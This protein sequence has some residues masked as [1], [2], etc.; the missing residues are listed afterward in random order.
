VAP[1]RAYNRRVAKGLDAGR[2]AALIDALARSLGV[3]LPA[4]SR[5]ALVGYV[6]RVA[7]WNQKLDLTAARTAVA[8][9]EVLLADALILSDPALVP[10]GCR[11]VD[12]GSGV[13]APALPLLALRTDLSATLVEPK[14]KRVAF[15]RGVIG[16]LG[17][18]A[19][20]QVLEGRIEP[21]ADGSALTQAH[22]LALSRA[23]LAPPAWLALGTRLAPAVLVLVASEPLPDAPEGY[24]LT[25]VREYRL[26]E[27]DRP[28]KV[29]LYRRGP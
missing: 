14:H 16:A 13:G 25:R 20:A 12:L 29:G 1:A 9:C 28:R 10:V 6:Q 2:D 22:D 23:T 17:H 27:G 4:A 7:D 18:G 5:P 21:D 19:R 15:L 26:P 3:E 11:F 8:L 24:G